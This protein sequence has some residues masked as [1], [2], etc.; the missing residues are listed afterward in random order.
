MSPTAF[1]RHPV[2]RDASAILH[3]QVSEALRTHIKETLQPGALIP[4]EAELERRFAVSRA[5]VRRAIDDLVAEGLLVRRQGKGTY[6]S[7]PVAIYE[8]AQLASWTA[9]MLALGT[10]PRTGRVE[11]RQIAAPS[12]VAERLQLAGGAKVVWVWRLRLANGEPLSIM[13][14]YVPLALAPGLVEHGLQRESL[15]DEL[16]ETYQ[17]ALARSEDDVTARLASDEEAA[18]LL[19]APADAIIEVRRTT[20]LADGRPAEIAVV[21]SRADRYRYRAA[22]ATAP[23]VRRRP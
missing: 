11:V 14:N 7:E 18:L 17:L 22:F 3:Q 23:S 9:S 2:R 4:T 19:V 6:V 10:S 12:W 20:Y 15:Y 21:R 1:P 16:R 13:T 5:T 8:P